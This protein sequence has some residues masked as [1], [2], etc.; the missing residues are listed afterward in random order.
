MAE[1]K[2]YSEVDIVRER[3]EQYIATKLADEFPE[4]KWEFYTFLLEK[5]EEHKLDRSGFC[6]TECQR[7]IAEAKRR[8]NAI[9]VSERPAGIRRR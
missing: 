3:L 8:N 1:T 4:T 9:P 2:R 7:D 5:A 6:S